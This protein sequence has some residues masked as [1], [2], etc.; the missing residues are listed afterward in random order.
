M[1]SAARRVHASRAALFVRPSPREAKS[2]TRYGLPSVPQTRAREVNLISKREPRFF[3]SW[4]LTHNVWRLAII[5][6]SLYGVSRLP[7]D[8]L[9]TK[10]VSLVIEISRS[11][12][13]D[14]RYTIYSTVLGVIMIEKEKAQDESKTGEQASSMV[15]K[16]PH[17]FSRGRMAFWNISNDICSILITHTDVIDTVGNMKKF[18]CKLYL[19]DNAILLG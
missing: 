11:G 16:Q 15:N 10:H 3:F 17:F 18:F 13:V 19:R 12:P 9:I 1:T 6:D 8:R 2:Y 4:S 5:S 14:F 7:V